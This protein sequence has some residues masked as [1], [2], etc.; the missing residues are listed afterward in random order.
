MAADLEALCKEGRHLF[1]Q[2]KYREAVEIFSNVLEQDPDRGDVHE[3]LATAAF[4]LKNYPTAIEHF[5]RASQLRPMDAKPLVNLGAVYNRQE[6]FQKAADILKKALTRDGKSVEAYYNLG[7]AY[8]GLNQLPMAVNAYKEALKLNPRMLDA[9]QNL[10]NVLLEMNNPKNAIEQ[11]K[12]ALEINPEFERAQRGLARAE[13]A[14]N[15]AKASF[16]PFGRL[17]AEAPP[18]KHGAGEIIPRKLSAEE[19]TNDRQLL[20]RLTIELEADCKQLLELARDELVDDLTQLNR[21]V[22][23][24]VKEVS[25]MLFSANDKFQASF[26]RFQNLRAEL[27]RLEREL[28]SHESSVRLEQ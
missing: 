3:A 13:E 4:I 16:N 11:Y 25:K 20:R 5:T 12:K 2:G 1:R 26:Q 10:G 15:A 9:L 21:G 27:Q 18:P 22:Q 6:E 24:S 17:V 23:T 19:R 14:L 8:R 28:K 7:I